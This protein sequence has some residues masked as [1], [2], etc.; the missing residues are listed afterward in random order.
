MSQFAGLSD[1]ASAQAKDDGSK[2]NFDK[3]SSLMVDMLLDEGD[4]DDDT[5]EKLHAYV[6]GENIQPPTTSS[7]VM[8]VQPMPS[9]NMNGPFDLSYS[10]IT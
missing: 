6:T 9:S 10:S 3:E 8:Y 1:S 2:V 7:N 4:Y 5:P